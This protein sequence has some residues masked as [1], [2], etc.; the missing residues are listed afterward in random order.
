MTNLT[1]PN[2]VFLHGGPGLS[3]YLEEF[4]SAPFA[5]DYTTLFYE[6]IQNVD[7]TEDDFVEE[8]QEKLKSIEGEFIL[9]GH[10]WGG[11]L[12]MEYLKK[13]GES[14]LAG[15]V[16]ISSPLDGQFNQ[17]F[18]EELEKLDTKEPTEFDIFLSA[19]ERPSGEPFIKKLTT[20]GCSLELSEKWERDYLPTFDLRPLLQKSQ[21]PFLFMY[22][23]EDLR[24]PTRVL[25]S[26]SNLA[27]NST[28]V[29]IPNA[30][31]FPFIREADLNLIVSSIKTFVGEN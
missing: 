27:A 23:T 3:E 28:T 30:G 1:K 29:E 9:V 6:Q 11:C 13:Y 31:H 19:S 20:V 17:V 26:Y 22:G 16:L 15:I 18:E 24:V 21:L 2:I 5:N 8:L 25:R 4:F 12:A 10:S 14:R 7:F